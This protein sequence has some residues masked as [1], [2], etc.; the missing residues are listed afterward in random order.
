MD[1][2]DYVIAGAGSAGCVLA[3]RLSTSGRYTVLLI[4]AG[5]S[6]RR[7]WIKLPLGYAKTFNDSRVNWRY[8]VEADPGLNG[9]V[10][11]WP[12]GKGQGARSS[13]DPARSMQWLIC[14]AC[15]MISTTGNGRAPKAGTGRV[16]ARP[17]KPSK[18]SPSLAKSLAPARFGS[19]TSA[20]GC[21]PSR[22][23]S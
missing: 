12:R 14:A 17:M 18:R 1:S 16:S 11:Y 7:Y 8:S 19:A 15:R 2:F 21:I 5:G 13:A 6:D 10:A 4:E 23:I 3:D 22:G 20:S 9:R